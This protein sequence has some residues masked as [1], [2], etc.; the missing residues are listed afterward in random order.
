MKQTRVLHV[1]DTH[2]G[3][4]QYCSDIRRN[5]FFDNF[6]QTI[7]IAVDRDVDAVVHTGDLFHGS[8]PS[9]QNIDR[10]A[11]ILGQ[12]DRAGIPMYG[13]VGNHERKNDTQLLDLVGRMG[14]VRR[15][16]K[17]PTLVGNIALYGIDAIPERRWEGAS[18]ELAEPPAEATTTVLCLHQSL[19]PPLDEEH[20]KHDLEDVIDRVGIELDGIALGDIHRPKSDLIGDTEVWYAGSTARTQKNQTQAGTVQLLKVKDGDLSRKQIGLDTR[21]FCPI[22]VEFGSDDGAGHLRDRL[23]Q[24]SLQDAVAALELTGERGAVTA[25]DAVTAA[26]EEGAAV[27]TVSDERGRVDLDSG[28]LDVREVASHDDAVEERLN[29]EEFPSVVHEADSRIRTDDDLPT[30][31]D[32]AADEFESDLR[33]AMASEFDD[34]EAATVEVDE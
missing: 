23:R 21:S 17:E 14:D 1:S 20:A 16:K 32:P 22:T 11:E 24:E 31:T 3:Y 13:I 12:L 30:R 8:N 7:E 2:L 18:F 28:S 10:C 19:A 5:D 25:N 26:R 6:E 9:I 27:V 33:E 29:D 15:L 4:R 34:E